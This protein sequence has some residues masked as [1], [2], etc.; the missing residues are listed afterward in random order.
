MTSGPPSPTANSALNQP[1][2]SARNEMAA[3]C[4]A[5]KAVSASWPGTALERANTRQKRPAMLPR[6]PFRVGHDSG[7]R[8]ALQRP[9]EQHNVLLLLGG[10]FQRQWDD[11][12]A[13]VD[14][15]L[16]PLV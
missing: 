4:P 8:V 6:E 12:L 10:Q 11:R 7:G 15:S 16:R 1:S 3:P 9:Q 14:V 5:R 2:A 13:V